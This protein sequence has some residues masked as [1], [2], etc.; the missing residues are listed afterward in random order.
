MDPLLLRRSTFQRGMRQVAHTRCR[1]L[2]W[3]TEVVGRW[4]VDVVVDW[5]M[6]EKVKEMLH[7]SHRCLVA[8]S[9]F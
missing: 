5:L 6:N 7:S 9:V 1:H 4:I 3:V 8:T 2:I